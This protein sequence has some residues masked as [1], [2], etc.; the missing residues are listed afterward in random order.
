[1]AASAVRLDRESLLCGPATANLKSMVSPFSALGTFFEELCHYY[2]SYSVV[3]VGAVYV[4][5]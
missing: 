2:H 1:M 5:V 4:D 3:K